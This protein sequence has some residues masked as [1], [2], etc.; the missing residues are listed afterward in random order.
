MEPEEKSVRARNYAIAGFFVLIGLLVVV[1]VVAVGWFFMKVAES[2]ESSPEIW[3]ECGEESAHVFIRATEDMKAVS[4]VALDEGFFE[5]QEYSLG[6]LA[7]NDA[8]VCKFKATQEIDEPL[9]FEVK[10]NGKVR[11]EVCNPNAP[12]QIW[13]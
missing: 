12:T 5:K 2:M 9:R 3:S 8:D 1:F 7:K 6:D 10:Y 13:D 4:C 11:K